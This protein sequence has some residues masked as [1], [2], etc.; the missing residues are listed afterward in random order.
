MPRLKQA[1]GR[2][3]T[4]RTT[5][6]ATATI[7]VLISVVAVVSIAGY[8]QS[9]P[10]AIRETSNLAVSWRTTGERR[11]VTGT[12]LGPGGLPAS[13]RIVW[14]RT[15]SDWVRADG[16]DAAGNFRAEPGGLVVT[17]VEVRPDG[18]VEWPRYRCPT[19]DEGLHFTI[20]LKDTPGHGDLAAR[21]GGD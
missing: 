7:F 9:H 3:R 12:L 1:D 4:S 5:L 20:R 16:P 21:D 10:P 8:L 6:S 19:T 18:F 15:H 17:A 14:L 13:G 11:V 2:G